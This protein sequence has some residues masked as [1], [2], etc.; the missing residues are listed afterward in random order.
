M[1]HRLTW[2][3]LSMV[4]LALA[5]VLGAFGVH[6]LESHVTAARLT[7]WQTAQYYHVIVSII[8]LIFAVASD[9]WQVP[10]WSLRLLVAGGLLF[11]GSLY[12]LVLADQSWLG[13]ITPL[14]G[15]FL[16]AGLFLAAIGCC[17]INHPPSQ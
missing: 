1:D 15:M 11:S 9:R 5:I 13:A 10:R 17:R 12:V 14:G 4:S 6:G 2:L 3:R 7:T 16:I 8:L